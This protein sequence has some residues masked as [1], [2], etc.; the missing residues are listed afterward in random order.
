ML[1]L[2]FVAAVYM[3]WGVWSALLAV[4]ALTALWSVNVKKNVKKLAEKA[5]MRVAAGLVEAT[6][7]GGLKFVFSLSLRD[8]GAATA[9]AAAAAGVWAAASVFG[10]WGAVIGAA[11]AAR[12]I[13]AVGSWWVERPTGE[14]VIPLT[15]PLRRRS[16]R[17]RP[18]CPAQ[19]GLPGREVKQ[20]M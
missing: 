9:W 13:L 6:V 20:L 1:V 15:E 8:V 18:D 14:R 11:V 4:T 10:V 19:V 16:N 2:A 3:T 12:V 17:E 5:D 7:L